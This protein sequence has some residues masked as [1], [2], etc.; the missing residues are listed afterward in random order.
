MCVILTSI[1]YSTSNYLLRI[2]FEYWSS[3]LDMVKK[4]KVFFFFFKIRNKMNNITI[5]I[6]VDE[7]N[8]P[9]I[10]NFQD[11]CVT[12]FVFLTRKCHG[13]ECSPTEIKMCSIGCTRT[14][15]ARVRYDHP[16]WFARTCWVFA[17]F[18]LII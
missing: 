6:E 1:L 5:K 15:R 4:L 16:Y 2:Y 11:S 13:T 12:K 8:L 3:N 18:D 9:C 7:R 14:S 17:T 10:T